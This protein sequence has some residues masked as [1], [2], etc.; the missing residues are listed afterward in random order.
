[1]GLGFFIN[2]LDNCR[3]QAGILDRICT[4]SGDISLITSANFFA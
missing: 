1:M 2:T 3:T 4:M